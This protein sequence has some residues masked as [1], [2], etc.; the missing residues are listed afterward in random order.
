MGRAATA[1]G[2]SVTL[3]V[4]LTPVLTGCAAPDTGR[5]G[6]APGG[7]RGTAAAHHD[8]PEMPGRALLRI[9]GGDAAGTPPARWGVP[10][11]ARSPMPLAEVLAAARTAA[12]PPRPLR[13]V[14]APDEA[15]RL[16]LRGRE[17][18]MDGRLRDAV[19]L[20]ERARRADPES[21]EI[22]REL[23]RVLLMAGQR[24]P[25]MELLRTALALDPD[26][27]F[28]GV[29]V[30]GETVEQGRFDEA[31]E[32]AARFDD[33]RNLFEDD[34][35]MGLR[36]LDAL[37]AALD[38]GGWNRAAVEASRRL[39]DDLAHFEA[40]GGVRQLIEQVLSHGG[41]VALAAADAAMRAGDAGAVRE[42]LDAAVRFGDPD[43]AGR[44]MR[45]ALLAASSG[46]DAAA[47]A[48]DLVGQWATDR[49][50]VDDRDIALAVWARRVLVG[51]GRAVPPL[52][53][54]PPGTEPTR[55]QRRLRLALEPDRERARAGLEQVREAHP[56]DEGVIRDL[57]ARAVDADGDALAA[58][59]ERL[60]SAVPERTDEIIEFLALQRLR[61]AAR[62]ALSARSHEIA[63]RLEARRGDLGG[64]W[65][66]CL[67]GLSAH[68]ADPGLMRLRVELAGSLDEPG[69]LAAAVAAL[70]TDVPPWTRLVIGRALERVGDF[71]GAAAR[72]R[73]V[74]FEL[75]RAAPV[76]GFLVARS[77][78]LEASAL[79]E[80]AAGMDIGPRRRATFEHVLR[81]AGDAARRDP[82]YREPIV[83]MLRLV[84]AGGPLA[85]VD[86]AQALL[87]EIAAGPLAGDVALLVIANDHL[88]AGRLRSASV[89]AAHA[90]AI[91]DTSAEALAVLS[92]AE[93]SMGR[94]ARAERI[95]RARLEAFPG[96]A[97]ALDQL[98]AL[99][100]RTGRSAEARAVLTDRLEADAGDAMARSRLEVLARSEGEDAAALRLGRERL[101][102]RPDGAR[103]LLDE[104]ALELRLGD[105][106]TGLVRLAEL[107]ARE[108]ASGRH[109]RLA[110]SLLA[111]LT[112]PERRGDVLTL[113]F[114]ERILGA[115]SAAPFDLYA[116]GIVAAARLEDI[117][118]A[119][120]LLA[121]AIERTEVARDGSPG[122]MLPWQ[123][124]AQR[125]IIGGAPAAAAARVLAARADHGAPLADD[126]FVLLTAM[127]LVCEAAEADTT[128]RAEAMIAALAERGLLTAVP[129]F[130]EAGGPAAAL[131]A[132]AQIASILGN[133][134]GA[135]A[136][137]VR[138]LELDP[139]LHM[140]ANNLAYMRLEA[141]TITDA[142]VARLLQAADAH[143]E[144]DNIRD[145]VAWLA[146]RFGAFDTAH[147]IL[148]DLATADHPG[149][150]LLEHLGDAR[151]RIGD[152]AG[153]L[154]AWRLASAGHDPTERTEALARFRALQSRLWGLLVVEPER[155]WAREVGAPG[156]RLREKI[157]VLEAGGEP[158]VTPTFHEA[159]LIAPQRPP[160]FPGVG[161]PAAAA[162]STAP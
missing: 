7:E 153:A 112:P 19:D 4:T 8:L 110:L 3:T 35:V 105:R 147:G 43:P 138:V 29:I 162:L 101:A 161:G 42:M 9:E 24:V 142:D 44:R 80:L 130:S 155:L 38:G 103:R 75:E 33:R 54:R 148:N 121:R 73:Q 82:A 122:G 69:L 64:A 39:L 37:C 71:E 50:A 125:I 137:L 158:P 109:Q 17:A 15:L 141:G 31:V 128:G 67:A 99:L 56:R 85:D 58:E 74:R 89:F 48:M 51:G 123:A 135:E 32:L 84:R 108:D 47:V 91:D 118:Q 97:V 21:V 20:L 81:L 126:A 41:R 61:P 13:R 156:E 134:A 87:R 83:L 93:E 26:E 12:P 76:D 120:S 70:G 86:R 55:L 22:L 159:G 6:A 2:W 107:S 117:P 111:Q 133:D 14:S 136:M 139:G 11:S 144:D 94:G 40:V 114:V 45:R 34:A 53:P 23:A 160:A 132:L 90:Y 49:S 152:R 27:V 106:E 98:L 102:G 95:L 92:T 124:L 131:F 25:A 96:D 145:T 104:A 66:R 10:G 63:A 18:R 146:Y 119:E 149:P 79:A 1:F 16:Y 150:E 113:L 52:P 28:A 77:F 78:L 72:A 65:R 157:A 59:A 46:S 68:P 127:R 151:Y 30:L 129:A 60:L 140:A 5:H 36:A 100:T 88:Q 115:E 154:S 143:P 116:V 57:L 62:T